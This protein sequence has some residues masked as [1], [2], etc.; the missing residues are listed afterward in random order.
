MK[1][2][3]LATGGTG[4]LIVRDALAEGDSLVALVRSQASA[5]LP[6]VDMIEGDAR[7]EGALIRALNGC[8]GVV[9]SLGTGLS[10]FVPR[11][12]P[13]AHRRNGHP[14]HGDDAQ[15]RA[16]SGL[17][18]RPGGRGRPCRPCSALISVAY[19]SR[20]I[21]ERF[22]PFKPQEEERF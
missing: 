6:G 20:L 14:G 19:K 11:G 7:D 18:Q 5:D 22:K 1:V 15:R 13:A 2:L 10:P 12:Q 4:R 8:Y 9:S 17:H 16:P 21:A 3:V